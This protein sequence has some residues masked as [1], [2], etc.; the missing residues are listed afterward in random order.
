MTA[1][2]C[3]G[4][5]SL[6]WDPRDLPIQRHWFEDGPLIRVDFLRQSDDGRITLVLES[7]ASLVRSLWAI[8]DAAEID[9]ACEALRQREGISSSKSNYIGRWSVG[10]PS[11]E[12]LLDLPEWAHAKGMHGVV[13]TALPP[14]FN[15]IEKAPTQ[16][17]VI[18]YFSNLT[19]A[20]R[21]TA[22]RYVRFVP[23]QIDTA[24]RR[25]IEAALHWTPRDAQF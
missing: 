22:E 5:G 18:Q 17:Q 13:W 21:D 16:K 4:W 14:R 24:Y 6:V 20:K 1:I 7:S 12:L 9:T 2:A 19:G 25:Q 23:R 10:E 11:P 15:G 3:L 8:M